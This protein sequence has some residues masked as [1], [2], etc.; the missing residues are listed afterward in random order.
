MKKKIIENKKDRIVYKISYV[1][2]ALTP[3]AILALLFIYVYYQNV[4]FIVICLL[5]LMG[6][7]YSGIIC[8]SLYIKSLHRK[9][10]EL[11]ENKEQNND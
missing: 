4:N 11:Y 1:I 9:I 5:I 2:F 8:H 3:V 10:E 6:M 7:I